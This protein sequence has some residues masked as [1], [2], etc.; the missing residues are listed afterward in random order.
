MGVTLSVV[1]TSPLDADDRDLL[2]GIAMLHL[3]IA[4]REGAL[5][6]PPDGPPD[7]DAGAGGDA[8]SG[9][10]EDPAPEDGVEVV[11]TGPG[12]GFVQ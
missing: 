4:N 1:I 6:G 7:G 3:A 8:P 10:D 11:P 9:R 2:A 12:R 5:E